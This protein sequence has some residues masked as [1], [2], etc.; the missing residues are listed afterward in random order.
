MNTRLWVPLVIVLW[1]AVSICLLL[2][3]LGAPA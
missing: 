3:A 2:I 1:V